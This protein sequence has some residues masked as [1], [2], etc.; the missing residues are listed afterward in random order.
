MK[1]VLSYLIIFIIIY[2][3]SL[4]AKDKIEW[5]IL[6][7]PPSFIVEG[8]FKGEGLDGK[9]MYSLQKQ[10]S[11]YDHTTLIVNETRAFQMFWQGK[12]ACYQGPIWSPERDKIAHFSLNSV[13]VPTFS[14][15]MKNSTYNKYYKGLK[16]ISLKNLL[17][18]NKLILGYVKDRSYGEVVMPII[19]QYCNKRNCFIYE[20]ESFSTGLIKMIAANRIGYIIEYPWVAEYYRSIISQDDVKLRIL[21]IDEL[22]DN[23]YV[24]AGTACTKNNWGKE[25]I[26]KINDILKKEIPT[27]RWRGI[28]EPWLDENAVPEYRKAYNKIILKQIQ[29][30]Q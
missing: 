10:L 26:N 18:E 4:F 25:I 3:I 5:L 16:S 19:S 12:N 1:K 29:K 7:I 17:N 11:E 30:G 6:D 20:G 27:Q 13:I 22:K 2:P 8:K 21:Q 9:V 23:Q 14:I 28:V 24:W 15:L